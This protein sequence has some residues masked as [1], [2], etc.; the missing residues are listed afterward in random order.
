MEGGGACVE[1]GEY[2]VQGGRGEEGGGGPSH[3]GISARPRWITKCYL[4][5]PAHLVLAVSL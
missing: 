1:G 4:H 3:G 2:L 5:T